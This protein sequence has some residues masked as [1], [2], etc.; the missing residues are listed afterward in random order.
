[1]K[2][3][4]LIMAIT[5]IVI[6]SIVS[7]N[8][9][10]YKKSKIAIDSINKEFTR[11]EN[12]TIQINTVITMMNKAIQK[13]SENN[14]SKDEKELFIENDTNSIK[15]Y[16]EL[17]SRKSIIPMEELILGKKTGIERVSYAFSDMTFRIDKIE[18]HKK[19]GQVKKIII[20]AIEE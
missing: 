13:N 20:Q 8:Y 6:I 18:Y 15:V 7:M 9:I 12:N 11:Y 19:T 3:F 5:V 1:M 17:K 16:L 4:L 2:K 14:I 10:E